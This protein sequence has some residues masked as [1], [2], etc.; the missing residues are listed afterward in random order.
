MTMKFTYNSNRPEN[1][2]IDLV[3][4]ERKYKNLRQEDVAD[5]LLSSKSSVSRFENNIHSPTLMTFLNYCR[6]IGCT[7]EISIKE[8]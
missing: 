7:L 8:V 1:E 4:S 3:S 2:L 5:V 6:A